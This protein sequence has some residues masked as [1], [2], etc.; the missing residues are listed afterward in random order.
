MAYNSNQEPLVQVGR[1]FGGAHTYFTQAVY[2]VMLHEKYVLKPYPGVHMATYVR[3]RAP[4][5]NSVEEP[6]F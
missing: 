1:A 4:T 2:R 6:L 3:S 5:E